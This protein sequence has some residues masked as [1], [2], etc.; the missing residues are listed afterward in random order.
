M[1]TRKYLAAILISLLTACSGNGASPQATDVQTGGTSALPLPTWTPAGQG[2]SGQ[3]VSAPYPDSLT[4]AELEARLA[5]FNSPDC[6][7]PCYNGLIP[8]QSGV[9][10]ALNFYSRLGISALDMQPGDYEAVLDGTGSL[11]A[12]LIR[13]SDILQAIDAGFNPPRVDLRLSDNVVRYL[14]VKWGSVPSYLT[15]VHVLE[16]MGQ[17]DRLD[18]GLILDEVNPEFVLQMVYS[19]RQT[20]FAFFGSAPS[21]GTQ[22]QVCLSPE[23]VKTALLG[24]FAPGEAIMAGFS[25]EKYLL[26]LPE[27]LGLSYDDFVAQVGSGGCLVIPASQWTAWQAL[28]NN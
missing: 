13:S 26:P 8:G 5:P 12:V 2:V 4:T 15:P 11:G 10:E 28:D 7:L 18:L 20:G 9:Q 3:A 1:Q 14:H 17:P 22:L 24:A 19:S 6:M 25:H 23:R 21:D 27:T 16:M